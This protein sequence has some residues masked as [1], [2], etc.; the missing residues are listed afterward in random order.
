VPVRAVPMQIFTLG[1]GG[2]GRPVSIIV[3][4]DVM[5]LAKFQLE[6]AK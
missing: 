4:P 3:D 5:S 2:I 6:Y 1:A